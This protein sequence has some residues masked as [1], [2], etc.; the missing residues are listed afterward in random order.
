MKMKHI[1]LLV[2]HFSANDPNF[3]FLSVIVFQEW[4]TKFEST[5][6]FIAWS[7]IIQIREIQQFESQVCYL[8][9]LGECS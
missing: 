8:V 7:T 4:R 3:K 2:K 6:Q 1:G 5:E 9:S